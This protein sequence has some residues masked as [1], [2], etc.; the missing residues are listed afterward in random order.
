MIKVET[1]KEYEIQL[2]PETGIFHAVRDG[3]RSFSE[4]T[5]ADIK[6]RISKSDKFSQRTPCIF[7]GRA[8]YGGM[9]EGVDKIISSVTREPNRYEKTGYRYTVY[10]LE[11]KARSQ[12]SLSE[13][14]K[15]T[16]ENRALIAN[17]VESKQKIHELNKKIEELEKSLVHFTPKDFG[18]EEE[19]A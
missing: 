16:D 9:P 18:F 2:D 17:I 5:L 11:G 19:L 10:L 3:D 14:V 7:F 13:I 12:A 15:P 1:F 4:S 6:K 8:W